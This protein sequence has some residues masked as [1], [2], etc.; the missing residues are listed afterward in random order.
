MTKK[1]AQPNIPFVEGVDVKK[2]LATW[3]DFQIYVRALNNF[4]EKY[5]NLREN[6]SAL[7]EKKDYKEIQS[8]AHALRGL[9]GN[10]AISEIHTIAEEIEK[11]AKG[12]KEDT[13]LEKLPLLSVA[14][15]KVIASI[16]NLEKRKPE[17]EKAKKVW[18]QDQVVELL[19]K[20]LEVLD[21]YNP[22]DVEPFLNKLKE[23]ISPQQI[24]PIEN[25]VSKF[26]FDR[27]KDKT[28]QLAQSLRIDLEK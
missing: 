13:L 15:S 11:A 7:L 18:D 21:N 12:K 4:A 14:L 5:K 22:Y 23:Y 8:I 17:Q 16:E 24:K 19:K 6:M 27:A 2:G 9:S 25:S 3:Q 20:I 10:L 26:N 28:K 1:P